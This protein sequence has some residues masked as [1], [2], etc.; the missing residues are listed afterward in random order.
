MD[1]RLQSLADALWRAEQTRSP[2]PPLT[3][4]H[5]NLTVEDAYRIQLANVE[6]RVAAGDLVV[7][8]KIGL[9]SKPMQLQLGVDQPD[10]G[11]LFRSMWF[12]SGA[13]VDFPLLQPKVEPEI[14]FILAEDLVGPG[15]DM[16]RVFA[17]TRAVV[18]AIE[19]IDSRIA[20]WRIRLV[21]T[22]A[23]NASAG[24]FVLGSLPT[25]LSGVDLE[26]VGGVLKVNGE[27]VQ[28]GAGAAVMGHPAKAVAWLANT[29]TELGTPLRA[30]H[31]VLSGAVS[32]A[33]PIQPGDHVHLSFGPLGT[34]EFVWAKKEG[35]A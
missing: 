17:A 30:G 25:A 8:H 32:A 13:S 31:V 15:V 14:A 16:H 7:G 22:V 23:D 19:I 27:V 26:T 29:L 35:S 10:F 6:R 28:T 24:C 12:D 1:P 3:D 20:D 18:P 2:I 21:D 4:E 9:T 33:Q 34:V 11:H 5:A